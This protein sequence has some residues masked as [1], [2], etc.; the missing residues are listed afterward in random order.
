MVFLMVET[1][2]VLM[3]YAMADGKGYEMVE[4]MVVL[5]VYATVD[6]R[7]GYHLVF[8]KVGMSVDC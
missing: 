3:V 5:M 2:V 1:K 6:W 7:D 4:M 8:E